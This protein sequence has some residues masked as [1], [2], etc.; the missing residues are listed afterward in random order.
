MLHHSRDLQPIFFLYFF[1]IQN[2]IQQ[3]DKMKKLQK[4]ML[5]QKYLYIQQKILTAFCRLSNLKP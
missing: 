3:I 2:P 1:I 4:N 5:Y